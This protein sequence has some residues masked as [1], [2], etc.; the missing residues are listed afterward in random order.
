MERNYQPIPTLQCCSFRVQIDKHFYPTLHW[1]CDYLSMLEL[2]L[3][4][5]GRVTHIC[6]GNLTIIGSDTGL[7][8]LNQCWNIVSW[9]A[10]NKL[11][12]NVNQNSYIFIK[13]IQLKMLS[14]KWRPFC[15][16]LNVLGRVSKRLPSIFYPDPLGLL[17]WHWRN[18]SIVPVPLSLTWRTLV[19][20]FQGL[21]RNWW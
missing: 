5:W 19:K 10:R 15:L 9:T 20:W 7:H 17:H 1:A 12:W 16:G 14:G 8:Y 2:K 6:V 13:K 3:T 11:Q 18:L 4:H 21:I